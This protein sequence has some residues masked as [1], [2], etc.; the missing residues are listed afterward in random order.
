MSVAH[1][2]DIANVFAFVDF[3]RDCLLT[4]SLCITVP[5]HV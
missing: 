3:Q 1:D 2:T 4:R 5:L